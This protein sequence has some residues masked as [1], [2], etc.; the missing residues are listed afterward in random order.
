MNPNLP[1]A[2]TP[3]GAGWVAALAC[4]SAQLPEWLP[5]SI[6]ASG[7]VTTATLAYLMYK[8]AIHHDEIAEKIA[9]NALTRAPD[10]AAAVLN[11]F[12][13]RSQVYR[14]SNLSR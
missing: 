11:A 9:S 13:G 10:T 7:V 8:Q 4:L 5:I 1:A 2:L 12:T 3:T 6:I 14:D